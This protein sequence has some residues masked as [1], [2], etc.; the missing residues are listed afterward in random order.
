MT[1]IE[2]LI[3]QYENQERLGPGS[4]AETEKALS[5]IGFNQD[6][7]LNILDIG[8]GTGSQTMTL[9]RNL[10]GHITAVDLFPQFLEKLD[11]RA[12]DLGYGNKITTTA[13]SMGDLPFQENAFDLIWSEG[14]IYNMGF[15]NGLVAWRRFSKPGGYLAV[16]EAS[17]ITDKRP[18]EVEEY[19]MG[20][21][22]WMDNY[23][24]PLQE[25]FSEFLSRYENN[26]AARGIVEGEKKEIEMY[27]RFNEFYSYGFFVAKK[28]L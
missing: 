21:Y 27:K 15:E 7:Y 2:L 26:P 25:G 6:Q 14:A 18:G 9:A 23:Y 8:C 20:E 5:L 3:D 10:M 16:S 13:C 11:Q 1:E 24:L 22:C 4:D 12:S 17:W 19:W 28:L